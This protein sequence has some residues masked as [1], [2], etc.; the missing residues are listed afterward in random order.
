VGE[1]LGAVRSAF[2][3]RWQR[4]PADHRRVFE[5]EDNASLDVLAGNFA[6]A[7]S[8]NAEI[9]AAVA[10]DAQEWSHFRG[11]YLR[12]LLDME[13]GKPA[14]AVATARDYMTRR[15]AWSGS[16]FDAGLTMWVQSLEFEA[17]GIPA[18][19][20]EKLREGWSS[21]PN[22]VGDMSPG[23]VWAVA[24]AGPVQTPDD[25]ARALAALPPGPLLD[26]R[27]RTPDMLQRVGHAYLLGG[28]I[29]DAI[30][31]LGD[32]AKSCK[33]TRRFEPIFTT[34]ATYD[35]G[36]AFEARGDRAQACGA[37]NRVLARWG[38]APSSR[39]AAKARARV[40]ALH[41]GDGNGSAAVTR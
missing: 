29:D 4:V 6:L 19:E 35:L 33:A 40:R 26:M 31:T 34:W 3:L 2:E 16:S 24:Y 7:F 21:Q 5:A 13:I 12:M 22:A 36:Q 8:H 32:A 23:S 1:P 41:C 30:A 38:G 17:G 10:S 9:D 28:R 20:F 25:A 15:S 37:Y 27:A 14:E 39:T 18:P 11:A